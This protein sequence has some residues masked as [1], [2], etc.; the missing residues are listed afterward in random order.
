MGT[1]SCQKQLLIFTFYFC[2]RPVAPGHAAAA[3]SDRD[4]GEKSR[5]LRSSHA[6]AHR[7]KDDLIDMLHTPVSQDIAFISSRRF[8]YLEYRS[9]IARRFSVMRHI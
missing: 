5:S 8:G 3:I 9:E 7:H 4:R 1:G 6:H 2:L